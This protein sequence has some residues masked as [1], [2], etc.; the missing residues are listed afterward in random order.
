MPQSSSILFGNRQVGND[1]PVLVIA[2][3]GI[4]H[5]GDAEVCARMVEAA[6]A[7][8]ADA[9]KLQTIDPD[10][11]YVPGTESHNLFSTA[12]LSRE[13]TAEIFSLIRQLGAEPFTTVGDF[14]TLDW[15]RRLDPSSYKIS[16]GLLTCLP[17]VARV[18][19]TGKPLL[20]STGMA[21]LEDVD[22]AVEAA[23][24]AGANQLM[25]LQC[26]SLYPAPMDRLDLASIRHL[27]ER[28]GLLTGFSDHSVGSKAA[29]LAVAAG[30]VAIEKHFSLDPSRPSFDHAISLDPRGFKQ[31]VQVIR[32]AE[33]ARGKAEHAILPDIREKRRLA[34]RYLG[35]IQPIAAGQ[36]LTEAN[37][38]FLR[39]ADTG[40]ALP[41]AA[42]DEILG[43]RAAT[44]LVLHTP[45]TPGCYRRD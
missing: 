33:A 19:A 10:R 32:E 44:D 22:S 4:N 37:V 21:F 17:I 41:A 39:L 38:G 26:T 28:Y 42:F 23:R 40:N 43:A 27:S 20:M 1:A 3:I 36:F 15:V 9:I 18:A 13:Q 2:E 30:A 8:G 25:L 31:M 16:S 6:V 12:M 7:A 35:A 34:S 45:L 5:E 24:L 14:A 29:A 11:N